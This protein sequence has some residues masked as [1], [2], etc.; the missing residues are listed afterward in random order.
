MIGIGA[1]EQKLSSDSRGT[2]IVTSRAEK[3]KL[4]PQGWEPISSGQGG[5]LHRLQGVTEDKTKDSGMRMGTPG[6]MVVLGRDK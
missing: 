1:A 6:A 3:L 4:S 2:Y 5:S